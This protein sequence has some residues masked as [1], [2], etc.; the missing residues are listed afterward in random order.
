MMSVRTNDEDLVSRCSEK[1]LFPEYNQVELMSSV[2]LE[3]LSHS[4]DLKN[5]FDQTDHLKV[6]IGIHSGPVVAGIVGLS[7]IQ[8]CLFGDTVNTSSRMCSNS[9][10]YTYY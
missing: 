9:E 6:Q 4:Y 3:I 1:R 5:P 7:N 10:V 2:A 8:F